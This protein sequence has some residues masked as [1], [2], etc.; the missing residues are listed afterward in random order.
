MKRI[1]LSICFLIFAS[2]CFCQHQESIDTTNFIYTFFKKN[3]SSFYLY[4][5]ISQYTIAE[6]KKHL[7]KGKFRQRIEDE[8]GKDISDS[9]ILTKAELNQLLNQLN[10]YSSFRWTEQN[11]NNI[12]S[13]K[14]RLIQRD[15]A[16]GK[17]EYTHKYQI[18]PPLFIKNGEYCFFYY[19][20][21]CGPLCGHGELVLYKK[22]NKEWKYWWAYILWD[23]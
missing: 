23:E 17:Y 1:T 16:I 8:N 4:T 22:E 18:V 10:S 19:D 14:P 9:I 2:E 5:D 6:I 20:Y 21:H 13:D 7:E 3:R 11:I 12:H 15:T